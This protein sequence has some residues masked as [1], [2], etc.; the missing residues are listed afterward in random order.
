[1]AH[2]KTS[3]TTKG[4]RQPQP[5]H[6]GIKRGNGS[7]VTAGSILVRQHGTRFHPGIGAGR[8]KDFT[9]FATIS[10]KVKFY[11]RN[12]RKYISVTPTA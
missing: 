3:A 12:K 6:L 11:E 7:I 1:M 9:L 8:G 10:G 2:T 5:K 4:S